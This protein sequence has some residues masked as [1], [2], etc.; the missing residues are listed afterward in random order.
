MK[1]FLF[2]LFG[3]FIAVAGC[4]YTLRSTEGSKISA[5]QIQEIK[6]GKTSEA[7]LLRILGPP[8]KKEDKPDGTV[9]LLYVHRQVKSLTL[10]GGIVFHGFIE[11][12]EEE[13]FEIIL[14]EGVVQSY[15]FLKQ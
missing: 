4:S 2:Y 12:E 8:S 11:K 5:A 14:K 13:S 3:L 15:Q 6:L 9:L 10:P 7:D 1:S